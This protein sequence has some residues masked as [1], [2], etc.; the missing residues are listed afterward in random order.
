MPSYL[1]YYLLPIYIY[2]IYRSVYDNGPIRYLLLALIFSILGWFIHPEFVLYSILFVLVIGLSVIIYSIV[3][4]KTFN[5]LRGKINVQRAVLLIFVLLLG[6]IYIFSG[7]AG[8]TNQ[9]VLFDTI[10][11]GHEIIEAS[12]FSQLEDVTLSLFELIVLA[13]LKYGVYLFIPSSVAL[14]TLVCITHTNRHISQG[15]IIFIT[16]FICFG[17]FSLVNMIA[18]TTIGVHPTRMLKYIYLLSIFILVV[19]L[20]PHLLSVPNTIIKKTFILALVV[21]IILTFSFSID[22]AYGNPELGSSNYLIT[23]HNKESMN[24]F[25]TIRSDY[26][27]IDGP[28]AGYQYPYYLSLYGFTSNVSKNNVRS[29]DLLRTDRTIS[30]ESHLGYNSIEYVGNWYDRGVYLLLSLPVGEY[31]RILINHTYYHNGIS[32]NDCNHLNYD[33]SALKLLNNGEFW[34]YFSHPIDYL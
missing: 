27:Q 26:Y 31:T 7:T 32:M 8:F 30:R 2:F 29:T 24:T 11:S 12:E 10:F 19:Y 13:V 20:I 28:V 33:K 3:H 18:G 23:M 16:L 15:A 6:F 17:L 4:W 22:K 5:C 1:A 21:S 9:I 34:V 14:I 25:F